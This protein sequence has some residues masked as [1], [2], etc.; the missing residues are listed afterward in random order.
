MGCRVVKR[1]WS[2]F[3]DDMGHCFITGSPN[4]HIHH[5][6]PG[7]R[8]KVSERYGFTVPLVYYLHEFGKDSVHEN[9]NDGLDL[10]LKQMAQEY[11][12][13]HYGNR[14]AFIATFGKSYL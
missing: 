8:R 6:F 12:E 3:T 7:S 2:V 14:K 1:V 13:S 10:K 4:V 9:P 11:W 5:I